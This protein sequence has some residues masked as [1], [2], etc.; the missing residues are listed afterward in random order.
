M[1]FEAV[2]HLVLPLVT[3]QSA[4]GEWKK[5]EVIFDIPGEFNRK[6]CVAFWNDRAESAGAMKVGER[7]AVS[8]NVTSQERNGRWFTEVR[9][10]KFSRVSEGA[11]PV[12]SGGYAQPQGAYPSAGYGDSPASGGSS[13]AGGNAT[14]V[15]SVSEVDDLPF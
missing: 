7:L 9:G 1:D 10:W 3:G 2:V 5:Q 11:S 8:A 14:S 6:I 4:R 13:Y 15:S 12:A